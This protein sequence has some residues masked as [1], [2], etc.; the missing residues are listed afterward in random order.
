VAAILHVDANHYVLALVGR[1]GQLRLLDPAAGSWRLT[2]RQFESRYRWE[3]V[4][5]LV[6]LDRR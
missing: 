6:S 4:M 3:G 2:Q 1:D 5:L